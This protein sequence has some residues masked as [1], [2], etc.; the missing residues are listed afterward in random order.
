MRPDDRPRARMKADPI[1]SSDI[2]SPDL[3][4]TL[5][6]DPV[7]GQPPA[8]TASPRRR[9]PGTR[10]G[11]WLVAIL[12]TAG[13]AWA[14][15]A[16]ARG[17]AFSPAHRTAVAWTGLLVVVAL[18]LLAQAILRAYQSQTGE[19]SADSD[20][21]SFRRRGMKAAVM[22]QDGRASTSKTQ[23]ALWTGAV[24]WALVDLLLLA[25]AYPGGNLFANAVTTN[26]RPEYLVLLGLPVAAATAAKAAV[27]SANAW[28]GPMDSHEQGQQRGLS[29]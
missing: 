12:F 7:S 14:S 19:P 10:Y 9:R 11:W 1:M 27:A 13:A 17:T 20:P 6:K 4:T 22:G 21:V 5:T 28:N 8:R 26:W 2:D 25:R 15:Y 24:V 16:V 23:V 3:G 18:A 29:G